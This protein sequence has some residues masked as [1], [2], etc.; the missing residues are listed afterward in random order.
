MTESSLLA[1][2]MT[3]FVYIR[4]FGRKLHQEYV[5]CSMKFQNEPMVCLPIMNQTYTLKFCSIKMSI[6]S[7]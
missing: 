5:T 2:K 3:E 4:F 6:G 7:F 1:N